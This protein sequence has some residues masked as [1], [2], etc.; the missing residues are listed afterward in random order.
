MQ[1]NEPVCLPDVTTLDGVSG[2]AETYTVCQ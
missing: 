2:V 1:P